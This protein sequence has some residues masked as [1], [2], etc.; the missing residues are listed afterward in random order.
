MKP[1]CYIRT[2][3]GKIDW[4]EDCVSEDRHSL[5]GCH[6]RYAIEEGYGVVPL[7]A[8]PDGWRVV[9]AVPTTAM[10][11]PFMGC[12]DDELELAYAAMLHIV[13]AGVKHGIDLPEPSPPQ[14][15]EK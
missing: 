3:N 11:R 4:A 6:D 12:P 15:I 2:L 14:G 9:P 13:L 10:L 8:L 1:A 5:D 7:Y